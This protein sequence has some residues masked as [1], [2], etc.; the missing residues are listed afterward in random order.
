M[1]YLIITIVAMLG[2]AISYVFFYLFGQ[3]ICIAAHWIGNFIIRILSSTF[4]KC[5]YPWA[6]KYYH[7]VYDY[8][9][10]Y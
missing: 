8:S 2:L 6:E 1:N 7:F 3:A 10:R 4:E 5:K 9:Y